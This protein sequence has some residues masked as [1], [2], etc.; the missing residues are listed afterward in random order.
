MANNIGSRGFEW[1]TES[2]CCLNSVTHSLSQEAQFKDR[3]RNM[4]LP[5]PLEPKVPCWRGAYN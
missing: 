1:E 5:H 2:I 3:R 4:W